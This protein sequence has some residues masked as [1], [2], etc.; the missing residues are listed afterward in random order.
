MVEYLFIGGDCRQSSIYSSWNIFYD[1]WGVVA[2]TVHI[3]GGVAR[4]DVG[5][6]I[7]VF[8]V[9]SDVQKIYLLSICINCKFES[10]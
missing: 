7:F 4:L 2:M 6:E 1:R 5:F 8:K 9:Q 10:M 3:E